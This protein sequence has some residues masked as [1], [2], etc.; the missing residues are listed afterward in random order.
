M[1]IYGKLVVLPVMKKTGLALITIIFLISCGDNR[2]PDVSNIKVNVEVKRFEQDFFALD[3]INVM[4]SLDQLGTK[5]PVFLGDFL[6]GYMQLPPITDT[7]LQLHALIK[8]YIRDYRPIKDSVDKAFSNFDR[9]TEDIVKGLQ[10]VKYY[11]PNYAT[12]PYIITC[13]APL[14]GPADVITRNALAISLAHHL[15]ENFSYYNSDIGVQVL[16]RYRTHWFSRETI[17]VGCL[18]NIVG[19]LRPPLQPGRPLVE[20]MVDAGKTLYVLDK[21]MPHTPDTLKLNY[22]KRQLEFCQKNEGIIWHSFASNNLLFTTENALTDGFMHE[23]PFTPEFGNESP[24]GIG[25]FVGWQIVKKY[26]EKKS[27]LSLADLMKTD[28]K[29]IFEESKY[30]PN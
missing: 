27:G 29:T 21:V 17:A 6:F 25:N 23:G 19:D 14:E 24:G 7:S 30:K 18:K 28:V 15:G 8:Q 2:I 22:T 1:R 10:F 3:T 5:Y 12:P 13:V 4:G 26:M 16:P 20:Q 11:F 9:I